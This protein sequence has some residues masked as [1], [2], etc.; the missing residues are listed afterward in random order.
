MRRSLL[1]LTALLLLFCKKEKKPLYTEGHIQPISLQE[2]ITTSRENAIV[3]AAKRVSPAV[4]CITVTQV[5]VV[6]SYP[7]DDFFR[8]FF[9]PY[10][11]RK[12]VKGIGSGVII[13]PSGYILTNAHVV[14]DATEIK[15]TLPNGRQYQAEIIGV[16]NVIDLALLKIPGSGFPY[17]VLGNSDSLMIGEWAIALGNPFAFLLEDTQPSVTVGV[18][19]ALHRRVKS[20]DKDF[21]DMIQTDAAINPG[22]SGGPL[23]NAMG[24]VIGINTFIFTTS[25]GSEGVGFAIPINKAKRF[26]RDIERYREKEASIQKVKTRIG[27]EVAEISP[28]LVRK[29]RLKR[30]TG[31]VVIRV[32]PGSLGY[33]LGIR[34]GDV[35]LKV[36][37]R[38]ITTAEEFKSVVDRIG[39]RVEMLID[40]KGGE[41]H[42]FYYS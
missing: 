41:F 19:S 14:E 33:Q 7:F 40:R 12:K 23:V 29:Y 5:R 10:E 3:R 1:I 42:I 16:D 30:K 20:Q 11:Y 25:R 38:R 32:D 22:N 8:D 36:N 13:N 34:E 2:E 35:I 24:E 28:Y 26:I 31:V 21:K 17:A 37:S 4:V 9:F 6:T 27:L 39:H 15:V 18:I